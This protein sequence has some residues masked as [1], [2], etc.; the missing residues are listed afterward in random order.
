VFLFLLC[1]A[2]PLKE[3]A[4]MFLRAS[5]YCALE[6]QQKV[7][8]AYGILYRLHRVIHASPALGDLSR[9]S[10]GRVRAKRAASQG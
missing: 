9:L 7:N 1:E 6:A 10:L 4:T 2:L 8:A 5:T 3:T